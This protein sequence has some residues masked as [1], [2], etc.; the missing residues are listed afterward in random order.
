M[1]PIERFTSMLSSSTRALSLGRIVLS[2]MTPSF[3]QRLTDRGARLELLYCYDAC[4]DSI[5]G[6]S[7]SHVNADACWQALAQVDLVHLRLSGNSYGG[8]VMQRIANLTSL[9]RLTLDTC[10][11]TKLALERLPRHLRQLALCHAQLLD[12]DTD[13]AVMECIGGKLQGLESLVLLG[14]DVSDKSLPA[15]TTLPK[16]RRLMVRSRKVKD[17]AAWK[18]ALCGVELDVQSVA[19]TWYD[20]VTNTTLLCRW[21]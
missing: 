20:Y 10:D 8:W 9:Q 11:V 5:F 4:S 17:A 13:T 12:V 19:D 14:M 1:V 2:P 15:L 3:F 16:L 7:S 21:M 6:Y 18:S